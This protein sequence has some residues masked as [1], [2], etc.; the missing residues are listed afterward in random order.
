MTW[1][2]TG[3][4]FPQD[5]SKLNPQAALGVISLAK[6][7]HITGTVISAA[8]LGC[9]GFML[10]ELKDNE[11]QI[12]DLTRKLDSNPNNPLLREHLTHSM[13]YHESRRTLLIAVSFLF[14]GLF[15]MFSLATYKDWKDYHVVAFPTLQQIASELPL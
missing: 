10:K 4:S 15:Y 6:K 5:F 7:V 14:A 12:A 11:E 9:T 1:N 2:I 3:F 8:M 13:T